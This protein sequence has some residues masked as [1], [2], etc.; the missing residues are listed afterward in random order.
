MLYDCAGPAVAWEASGWSWGTSMDCAADDLAGGVGD[1]DMEPRSRRSVALEVPAYGQY[2][3]ALRS[4]GEETVTATLGRCFG[5]PW[6]PR[7][8]VARANETQTVELA[9]GRHF[10]RLTA[11]ADAAPDV[12]V[13]LTAR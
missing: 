11:A 9:A 4:S 8:T 3:L 13:S 10:L 6:Y 7:D 12:E 1:I 2:E 5:C